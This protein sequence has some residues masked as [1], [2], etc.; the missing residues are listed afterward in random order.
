MQV[1]G[2]CKTWQFGLGSA[3]VVRRQRV[4]YIIKVIDRCLIKFEKITSKQ[5]NL[6]QVALL[7]T[8]YKS[9]HGGLIIQ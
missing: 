5:I 7:S 1:I 2:D 6:Y 9:D 4:T 3:V 8:F